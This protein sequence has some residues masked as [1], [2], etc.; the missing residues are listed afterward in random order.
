M[1]MVLTRQ[2]ARACANPE[3]PPRTQHNIN[4]R[5]VQNPSRTVFTQ[6]QN[7]LCLQQVFQDA[8][9]L[10]RGFLHYHD[11]G[12]NESSTEDGLKI[13]FVNWLFDLTLTKISIH[14]LLLW[15]A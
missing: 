5:E 11:I 12:F 2:K 4:I 10:E 14:R 6:E 3:S 13:L 8:Q 1:E 15:Q 7:E 9:Y